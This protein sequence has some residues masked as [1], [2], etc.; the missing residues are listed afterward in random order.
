MLDNDAVLE[1]R[2]NFK[3]TGR[4]FVLA[5]VVYIRMPASAKAGAKAIV[6]PD[7]TIHG[8]I[9]GGC[10]QPAVI[11]A[12]ERTLKEGRPYLLP[13]S[14]SCEE[15]TVRSVVQYDNTPHN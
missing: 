10:A 6:E 5:T 2:L 14:P 9:G 4:P 13:I 12:A 3:R 7:G 1:R 8:W 11:K 15:A